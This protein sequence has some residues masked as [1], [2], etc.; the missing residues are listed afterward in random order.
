MG[1]GCVRVALGTGHAVG[2]EFS[3]RALDA[4][5]HENGM[6]LDFTRP[7]KP[8]EIEHIESFN[9]KLRQEYL[10]QHWFK[11]IDEVRK[12]IEAWRK[13]YN[14]RRPRSSLNDV[15]PEEYLRK[16]RRPEPL[17]LTAIGGFS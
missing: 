13:D 1:I 17:R 3:G 5:A 15:P 12:K 7:G 14:R 16:W 4:W 8:I 6:K 10:A 2:S 11:T 9:G